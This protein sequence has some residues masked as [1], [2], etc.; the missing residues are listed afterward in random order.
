MSRLIKI[1]DNKYIQIE[2][3]KNPNICFN[4]N[5]YEDIEDYCTLRETFD[6][7]EMFYK[8]QELKKHIETYEIEGYKQDEELN[9]KY[10]LKEL[11]L[12]E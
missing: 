7:F 5:E 3:Y 2:E 12:D 4:T 8:N 6:P 1:V 11:G 9:K 10:T